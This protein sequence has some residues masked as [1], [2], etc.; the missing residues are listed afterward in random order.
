MDARKL[1]RFRGCEAF[2]AC[3]VCGA[4]LALEGRALRCGAGHSFDVARQG[5][6]NLLRGGHTGAGEYDRASF[7]AR[8]RVFEAGLYAPIAEALAGA[9]AELVCAPASAGQGRGADA[10]VIAPAFAL[11]EKGTLGETVAAGEK[12]AQPAPLVLD[13]GCGEGYFARAVR[14]RTGAAVAAFDIAK[15]SV[16]L[17]AGA[18]AEDGVA[19]FVADLAAIPVQTG[20]AACVLNVFSPANYA[21]FARVLRPGGYVVKVVPTERHLQELRAAAG[22]QLAHDSY[23]NERVLRH[24]EERCELVV[25]RRVGATF[26]LEP[27]VA[28]ALAAMT[29]LF[30]HVDAALVHMAAVSEVTVEADI[31]VG[32]RA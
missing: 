7:A 18:A 32:R 5:Y 17:A 25:R 30:F 28:E 8:R 11:G 20:A 21:E 26:A 31:L 15:D 19:W 3:P 24:F 4:P 2:L 22:A 1:E 23:S 13:A 12:N 6:V 29:P 16:Q 27:D 9:V 14:K 10:G